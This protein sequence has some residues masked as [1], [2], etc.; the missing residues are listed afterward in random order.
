MFQFSKK[1]VIIYFKYAQPDTP[2]PQKKLALVWITYGVAHKE[3]SIVL[4]FTL[5]LMV[6]LTVVAGILIYG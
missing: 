6:N 1:S 4:M 2:Y 5:W 3:K